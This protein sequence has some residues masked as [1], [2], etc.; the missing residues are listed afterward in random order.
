M[1]SSRVKAVFLDSSGE[2]LGRAR[3]LGGFPP[4]KAG[5][6]APKWA[7]YQGESSQFPA[8]CDVARL[9]L[10]PGCGRMKDNG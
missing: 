8:I 6:G 7:G 2:R 1:P 3:D 5:G 10:S 9:M 4:P